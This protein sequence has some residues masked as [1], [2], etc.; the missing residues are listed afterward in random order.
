MKAML[1]AAGL[2]NRMRPLT[3]TTPKPLLRVW[4]ETLI[5][6]H[7][8]ALAAAGIRDVVVN[9]HHLGDQIVSHLGDGSRF[10][11]SVTYSRE[12]SLLET[13]GGI[14]RALHHLGRQ[15]FL[16]VSADIVT[17]FP[18]AELLAEPGEALAHLVMVPNPAHH[19]AGDFVIAGDGKLVAAP[20]ET[21]T[22]SGIGVFSPALF[23]RLPDNEPLP[24]RPLLKQAVADGQVTARRYAGRW[25][26][27]G[28]PERLIEINAG[29]QW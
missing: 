22:Y 20:G 6:R 18:M 26:D 14:R 11:L 10:G 17:D 1:L 27:I 5:D 13:A 29:E 8:R 25:A 7:C 28:T 23:D 2:G 12:E 16:V 24:L 9:V 3:E 4:G 19:P 15:P 21:S